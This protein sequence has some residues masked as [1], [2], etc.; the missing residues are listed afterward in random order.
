MLRT[1]FW[2]RAA[3]SLPAAVRARYALELEQAERFDLAISD[4]VD[5]YRRA[6][7]AVSRWFDGPALRPGTEL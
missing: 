2:N 3:A 7:T 1:A 6:R 4:T 5:A